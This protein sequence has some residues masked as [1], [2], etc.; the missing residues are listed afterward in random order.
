MTQEEARLIDADIRRGVPVHPLIAER[1]R[2]ILPTRTLGLAAAK[3]R[4]NSR[5]LANLERARNA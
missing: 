4:A 2:A 3:R 5:L 1:A